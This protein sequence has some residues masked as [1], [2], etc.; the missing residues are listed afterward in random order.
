M[1]ALVRALN[2]GC[3]NSYYHKVWIRFCS[4]KRLLF[5]AKKRSITI[6]LRSAALCPHYRAALRFTTSGPLFTARDGPDEL[7]W[8]EPEVLEFQSKFLLVEV[9]A[10][11]ESASASILECIR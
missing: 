10:R 9:E 8:F 1:G 3:S 4:G 5:R 2:V 11:S 6:A 7:T